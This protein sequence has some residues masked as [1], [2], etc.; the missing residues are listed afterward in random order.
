MADNDL[1]NAKKP[2]QLPD[3]KKYIER[4][5]LVRMGTKRSVE[6]T[7][8]GFDERNNL[9]LEDAEEI[10]E[11]TGTRTRIGTAVVRGNAVQ[12]LEVPQSS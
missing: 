12:N 3:L 9:V 8:R 4:R 11:K 5:V 6:G 10:N 7:L 2:R 1:P